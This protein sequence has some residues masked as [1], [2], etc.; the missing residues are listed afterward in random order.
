LG[1]VDE[2]GFAS[3]ADNVENG[4]LHPLGKRLRELVLE[5]HVSALEDGRRLD[6]QEEVACLHR[7]FECSGDGLLEHG[8]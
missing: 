3:F 1:A 8:S 2:A 5:K 7:V 4:G 6:S